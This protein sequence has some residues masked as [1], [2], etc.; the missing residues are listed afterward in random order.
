MSIDIGELVSNPL[1]ILLGI[2]GLIAIKAGVL[3]GLLRLFRVP[4]PATTE[5]SLLLGP[6]GEFAFIVIGLGVAKDIVARE[7]GTFVLA[8]TSLSMAIIPLLDWLGRRLARQLG[9]T[10]EPDQALS[11]PPPQERV[12]AI[13]IGC[14]RVGRLVSE[15]LTRHKVSHIIVE[16]EPGAV[17]KWRGEGLPV[18]FGDAKNPAFLRRCGILGAKGV[19][20]TVDAPAVA[21]EIV[22]CVRELRERIPVVARAGDEAHARRLYKLGVTD[23]V[24]ET[25]EASL[26]LSEA[27]LVGLGVPTGP[28]IASIHE[29]RDEFREALQGAAGR[30]TRGLRAS[31]TKTPG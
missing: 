19:I 5:I 14:G 9:E 13:V 24:P 10:Q 17:T 22:A 15:M 29:K 1:P 30:P 28:V 11:A 8:I 27:A 20:I 6:G 25:V 12:D 31:Q 23:A 21:D 26:Q 18:Y 3:A 7:T 16:S 2:V 4:W